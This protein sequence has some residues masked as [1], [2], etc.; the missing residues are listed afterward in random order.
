MNHAQAAVDARN[1]ENNTFPL[2]IS[3]DNEVIMEIASLINIMCIKYLK[4]LPFQMS[5]HPTNL[6]FIGKMM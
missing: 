6:I 5:K 1:G 2:V 4:L 3:E